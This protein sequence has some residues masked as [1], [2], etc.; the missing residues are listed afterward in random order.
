M[1]NSSWRKQNHC[2]NK[3][4]YQRTSQRTKRTEA[5][6]VQRIPKACQEPKHNENRKPEVNEQ[7]HDAAGKE[8]SQE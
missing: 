5:R 8:R 7:E 3:G 4:D 2:T 1:D 6:L